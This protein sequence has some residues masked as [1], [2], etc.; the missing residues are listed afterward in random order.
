MATKKTQD[1]ELE[2]YIPQ[3]ERDSYDADDFAGPDRSF[4]ITTQAQLDAAAHLIGHAADPAAVKAKAIA[5]AKRKGFKLPD[6]WQE[7]DDDKERSMG[8]DHT[9]EALTR[10]ANHE[11]YTGTHSHS[12]AA[13]GSQ[14]DDAMHEHSHTHDNDNDHGHSHE[15]RVAGQE[16]VTPEALSLYAP[17]VRTDTKDW[18]VE[19]QVTSD[20]VDHYGTI[21]DYEASKKAFQDWRG[22][23][24]EQHDSK[25]AVGRAIEVIP[26]DA[27]RTIFLRARISKG[28]RDTW[29]KILDGTLSGFSVGADPRH[30]ETSTIMRNGKSIPVYRVGK[31]SEVSVVD[32][33]GSPGCDIVPLVRAD[34]LLTDVIDNTEENPPVVSSESVTASSSSLSRAGAR[35]SSE[36][37]SAMH[38]G[39]GHTLKAAMSQMQNCGCE[40]CQAAMKMIDPDHDGDIDMGGY[41]D[42]DS[43][44][45]SL[46]SGGGDGDMER[47]L[48]G[49]IER[50]LDA[51]LHTVYARLQG[52]AGTLARVHAAPTEASLHTLISGAIERAVASANEANASSLSEVRADVSAVK[53]TVERIENTPMPGA[54]IQNA[55]SLPRPVEKRLATDPYRMPNS[56]GATADAVAALFNAGQLNTTEKQVD[57]V[58]AALA[59]Q[60]KGR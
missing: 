52:I 42:P 8:A 19:G 6:A 25:K 1:A 18:I 17:I 51:R 31:W 60:R 21:F 22:N 28:A 5:I 47:K 39:I 38:S 59:A 56:A 41:D 46:Y 34:G 30:V 3:K 48:S 11:P 32:N 49:L 43:D 57:A 4:P 2:R 13:N 55:G 33:P 53:A 27:A 16:V 24:R 23:I 7:K 29:E 35:I 15:E 58:A 20:Q 45:Q 40:D 50:V 9:H 36:T 10:A 14:G 37:K 54:P 12:H 44:W 26:D